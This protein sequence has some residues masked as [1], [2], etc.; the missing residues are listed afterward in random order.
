MA[1]T[2]TA[3][4]NCSIQFPFKP[5]GPAIDYCYEDKDGTLW[6]GNDEY[7][8]QVAYCPMCGFKARTQPLAPEE[9]P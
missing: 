9:L 4:H 6:C 3:Y 2:Q 8:T 1:D 5:H 7:E